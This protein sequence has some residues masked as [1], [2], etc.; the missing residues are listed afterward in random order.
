MRARGRDEAQVKDAVTA[1]DRVEDQLF[2][3]RRNSIKFAS[4]R[5]SGFSDRIAGLVAGGDAA[6]MDRAGKAEAD[7]ESAVTSYRAARDLC[8][9]AAAECDRAGEFAA[10]RVADAV[11]AVLATAA[12]KLIDQAEAARR[13]FEGKAAVVV[14]PIERD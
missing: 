1:V 8:R 3:A 4:R 10:R 9:A 2:E 12:A 13:E 6:V 11:L 7:A 14:L 5:G